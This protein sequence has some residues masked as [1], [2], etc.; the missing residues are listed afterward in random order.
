MKLRKF[1]S[2]F[3]VVVLIL[4]PLL[5]ASA[6]AEADETPVIEQAPK[7]LQWPEGSLASYQCVC[8]NDKGHEKF[9]YEWHI[10]YEEKDYI[11]GMAEK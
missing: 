4:A 3:T 1:L 7:N 2:L 10:V 6:F 11:L 8:E 5:S 9:I